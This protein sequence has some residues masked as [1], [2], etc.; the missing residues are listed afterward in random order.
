[1]WMKKSYNTSWKIIQTQCVTNKLMFQTQKKQKMCL[2]WPIK[3]QLKNLEKL[4]VNDL[5]L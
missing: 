3:K 2:N 1:M 5:K 4:F